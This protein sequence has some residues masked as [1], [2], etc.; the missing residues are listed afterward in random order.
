MAKLIYSAITSLEGYV[1]DER[2]NFDWAAPD[3]EV[4]AFVN[5]LERPIG[6]NLY[7]RRMYEVMVAWE[8][9]STV[10]EPS[11]VADFAELW[12]AADKV[13]YSRTLK[14]VSSGR[15]RIER[16]FEPDVVRR[17]KDEA[18][19]DISIGGPEVA[20][21]AIRAGLVDE[22]HLFVTP[23]VVGGGKPWLPDGLRVQLELRDVCRFDCGVVHLHYRAAP[24]SP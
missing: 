1:A 3:E 13:V 21:E 11:V 9:M 8:T 10:D 15:T 20:A 7:G 18:T 6:T 4:H 2:G 12:R 14:A 19:R 16:A 23:V 24:G 17:M 5:E 22:Y